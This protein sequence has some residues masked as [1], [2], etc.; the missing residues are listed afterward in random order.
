[1]NDKSIKM[2]KMDSF[3]EILKTPLCPQNPDI[4]IEINQTD[5]VTDNPRVKSIYKS[6]KNIINCIICPIVL[7]IG[8][9][10]CS[11]LTYIYISKKD[12]N[13]IIIFV[14]IIVWM[15][16]FF[17]GINSTPLYIVS[18]IN[19]FKGTITNKIKKLCC[20]L[21]KTKIYHF[22]EVKKIIIDKDESVEYNINGIH[23]DAFKVDF[24][25]QNNQ[26]ETIFSGIIDKNNESQNAFNI[27]K[28]AF[29]NVQYLN[30]N[31]ENNKEIQNIQS[32]NDIPHKFIKQINSNEFYIK[33][34][35]N[36]WP[37]KLLLLVSGTFL[38]LFIIILIKKGLKENIN[39]GFIFGFSLTAFIFCFGI[40]ALIFD[41]DSLTFYLEQDK[42]R[43]KII[44]NCCCIKNNIILKHGDFQRFEIKLFENSKSQSIFYINN[45]GKKEYL[46]SLDFYGDEASYLVNVL[47][48]Y[49]K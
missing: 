5:Y 12:K 27:F 33:K 13:V 2:S 29:S 8:I 6:P 38:S 11:L 26:I 34:E 42:I 49:I 39:F 32:L 20:C 48:N 41:I 10:I 21:S 37:L 4:P 36:R 46:I 9:F 44:H 15:I 19:P 24:L 23:Y 22:N 17:Y 45:V 43:I 47:N 31:N 25:L 30:Q 35:I 16:G 7:I 28:N 14:F 40:Y 3:N 1:M 18:I